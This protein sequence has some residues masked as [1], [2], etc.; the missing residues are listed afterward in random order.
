M[1]SN[2]AKAVALPDLDPELAALIDSQIKLEVP[3][4]LKSANRNSDIHENNAKSHDFV[5]TTEEPVTTEVP[6]TIE[7]FSTNPNPTFWKFDQ[8][9]V[10]IDSQYV[11][12]LRY[13]KNV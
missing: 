13:D 2:I 10:K 9:G 6:E 7:S 1:T 5:A 11:E 8:D 12:L 4:F 3:T